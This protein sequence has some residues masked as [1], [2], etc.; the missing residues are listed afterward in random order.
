[1]RVFGIPNPAFLPAVNETS[2]VTNGLINCIDIENGK[3]LASMISMSYESAPPAIT[4]LAYSTMDPIDSNQLGTTGTYYIAIYSYK[5]ASNNAKLFS[6]GVVGY[7]NYSFGSSV[8]FSHYISFTGATGADGYYV[9]VYTDTPYGSNYDFFIDNTVTSFYVDYGNV[10]AD[11][12]YF[13]FLTSYGTNNPPLISF[14][15]TGYNLLK[16]LTSNR[17]DWEAINF[18]KYTTDNKGILGLKSDSGSYLLCKNNLKQ[19]YSSSDAVSVAMWYRPLAAGQILSELGQHAINIGWHVA[20]IEIEDSGSAGSG[21]F[22]MLTWPGINVPDYITTEPI[23]YNNWY[24]LSFVHTGTTFY[25]YLN[26]AL[27]GSSS[28]NRTSPYNNGYDLYYAIAAIDGTNPN[29]STSAYC[30]GSFG[31]FYLYNRALSSDEVYQ[32]YNSTKNRFIL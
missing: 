16:D 26:G 21:S 30:S 4:N 31:S 11:D 1:M 2:V 17:E 22:F 18:A 9:Y 10:Y 13:T 7:F 32:N 19:Y 14:Y 6:S 20:E 24:H 8:Y 23:P 29:D 28:F 27:I 5:L 15:S 3:T 25:S 12:A